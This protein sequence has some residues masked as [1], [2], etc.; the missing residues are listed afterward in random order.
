VLYHPL[1]LG[2]FP[3]AAHQC[4]VCRHINYENLDAFLCID[5]GHCRFAKLNL[6]FSARASTEVDPITSEADEAA[7]LRLIETE[8]HKARAAQRVLDRIRTGLLHMAM[9]AAPA[10]ESA[11][12]VVARAG[13]ADGAENGAAGV[14]MPAALVAQTRLYHSEAAAAAADLARAHNALQSV[15]RAVRSIGR[16]KDGREHAAVLI[17]V[18]SALVV[19]ARVG[20]SF[21]RTGTRFGATAT[22]LG[23]RTRRPP[24]RPP[25]RQRRLRVCHRRAFR[26][27]R[28]RA[29][30][31]CA[32]CAPCSTP[33]R[34]PRARWPTP[35]SRSTC[36]SCRCGGLR[37]ASKPAGTRRFMLD[38]VAAVSV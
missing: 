17:G 15:R 16:R 21:G 28:T 36:S 38:S 30:P 26:A 25:P 29:T 24:P 11:A 33:C 20:R 37:W 7:C 10:S 9:A 32:C 5:C 2:L 22:Q 19:I 8:T 18:S 13:S 34:A 23:P 14:S 12:V 6:T 4:R 1:H 27:W 31:S 3:P 35:A